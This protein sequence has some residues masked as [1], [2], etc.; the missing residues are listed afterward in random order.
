MN[1]LFSRLGHFLIPRHAA[2]MLAALVWSSLAFGGQ[3]HDAVKGGDLERVKRLLKGNPNLVFSK[4]SD[5]YKLLVAC[6]VTYV[7]IDRRM[8]IRTHA[9][10]ASVPVSPLWIVP[11]HVVS[12]SVSLGL[13]F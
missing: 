11:V 6:A 2:V 3:I 1:Y 12:N 8:R 4:D 7:G 5:D 13:I 10:H 9:A